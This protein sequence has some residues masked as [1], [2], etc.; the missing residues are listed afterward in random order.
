MRASALDSASPRGRVAVTCLYLA[1]SIPA[2]GWIGRIPDIKTSLGASDV[3]WGLTNSLGTIGELVGF[4]VIVVVVGRLSTRWISVVS[5]LLVVVSTPL[6]AFASS[7]TALIVSM[8]VWMMASKALGTTMGALALVEQQR[9]GRVLMGHYDAVYSV[10]MFV[11][12]ALAWVCIRAGIDAEVQFAATNLLLL[13]GLGLTV[14]HLP[15]EVRSSVM[16]EGVGARLRRRWR[17]ALILLAGISFTAS[18]IDG[19]LS[20]WG[21]ILLTE[22]A[23]GDAAWGA[24]VYPALMMTKILV[25]LWID[26]LVRLL[27]WS[28]LTYLSAALAGLAVV[29]GTTAANPR[30][31]LIGVSLVGAGTAVLGPMVNTAAGQQPGVSGGEARTMLE[32]GELP[33]YLAMPAVVGL[34]STQIGLNYTLQLTMLIALAAGCLLTSR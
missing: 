16:G 5:A 1:A 34:V 29:V 31:A 8:T 14:R 24:L 15:D 2:G 22:R 28:S 3:A 9:A 7:L 6:L 26:R 21:A 12:G 11:G 10:G 23:D 4:A 13:V 17:P 32:L 25:L 19:T 33:A 18:V 20:Q 27:G 30:L